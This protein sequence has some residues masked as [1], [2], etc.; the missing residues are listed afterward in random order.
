MATAAVVASPKAPPS[1]P[2]PDDYKTRQEEQEEVR[3][4]RACQST[5]LRIDWA[6]GDRIC[7]NCGLVDEEH[8]LDDR[9]EWRE[10]D[11][12]D[13]A[14]TGAASARCGMISVNEERWIGGLQP[15]T[16][17]K[18]VFGGS[19]RGGTTLRKTLV[20][21][22]YVTERQVE[23]RHARKVQN[24]KINQ[25]IARKR[26]LLRGQQ[27]ADDSNDDYHGL[28]VEEEDDVEETGLATT[29]ALYAEKWSLTRSLL[30]FGKPQEQAT[31]PA[32][33][34]ESAEELRQNIDSVLTAASR[35]LY[36][37][38]SI[39]VTA[40][41]ALKLPE[42]V[43][44]EAAN[45]L[46][47]YAAR[48]DSL[49]VRGVASMLKRNPSKKV[50]PEVQKQAQIALREYNSI[51]QSSALAAVLLFYTARKRGHFRPLADVCRAIPS[52][53]LKPSPHLE[54]TK[55]E[56]LLKLRHCS[57]AMT[58]VKKVFPDLARTRT[59]PESVQSGH[60]SVKVEN[61]NVVGG[62]DA[63]SVQNYVTHATH[64]LHLPPVAEAC[65]QILVLHVSGAGKLPLQTAALTFFLGMAGK[66][67]Q[68]LA[69]QS[70]QRKR[71][72][73]ALVSKV[74]ATTKTNKT[75]DSVEPDGLVSSSSGNGVIANIAAEEKAYEMLRVWS[76]WNDQT[77]WWR[78]LSEISKATQVPM[79]K[80]QD[81]YKQ[82]IHPQRY[83]LLKQLTEANTEHIPL[84][85]VLLPHIAL[86]AP[87]MKDS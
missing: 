10:Y 71:P 17:S 52:D 82:K 30:L 53:S 51:K 26:K 68:K 39:L 69:A 18:T 32:R 77:P 54:W 85:S 28:V 78:S 1:P 37:S 60:T 66:T 6:A 23:Q 43:L 84:S 3:Y 55:G 36:R 35:D 67:M 27:Q 22:H 2:P 8:S 12:P 11:N 65:L 5:A 34:M 61:S 19:G 74:E 4:C 21:C 45:H 29:A 83:A 70:N 9:P 15:T 38:Y 16:L 7:T 13:E 58:E 48:R 42:S 49:A 56:P 46:S 50:S 41:R 33:E 79:H 57:K 62:M 31:V 75:S 20:K 72:R 25:Q 76:A 47:G 14:N 86:A 80:I 44:T 24:A 73:R 81:H 40:G 64:N 59:V 63:S 87:L